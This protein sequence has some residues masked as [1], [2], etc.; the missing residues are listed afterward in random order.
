MRFFS[1]EIIEVGEA[2]VGLTPEKID[3]PGATRASKA[4]IQVKGNGVYYSFLS[5]PDL[6]KSLFCGAGGT[7]V[8][9]D[10]DNLAQVKFANLTGGISKLY[11]TYGN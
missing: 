7:I 8:I 1:D 5:T 3:N 11:I 6:N 10:Y 9:E 4:L 2:P